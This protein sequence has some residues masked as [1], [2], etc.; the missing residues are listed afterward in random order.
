MEVAEVMRKAVITLDQ[1]KQSMRNTHF[2]V[3]ILIM[4]Y[5]IIA[6]ERLIWRLILCLDK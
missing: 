6:L 3:I 4:F 1:Q 5:F 2:F